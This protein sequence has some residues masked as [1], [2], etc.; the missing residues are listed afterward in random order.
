MEGEIE[1][2]DQVLVIKRIRVT[3]QLRLENRQRD[4]AERVHEFHADY[5]PVARSIRDCI[6]IR[7]E[8][9]MEFG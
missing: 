1:T 5:C 8:L 3:Y 4:T 6:D 2:E 9:N 7:T